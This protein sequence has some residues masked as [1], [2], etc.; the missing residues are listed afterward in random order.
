[1]I[2]G[3]GVDIVEVNRIKNIIEKWGNHFL[4]KVYSQ[5]EIF[6][7]ESKNSNRFQSYA[8]IFAAKEAFVKATGTGFRN[9]RWKEVKVVNDLLG[10]PYIYLS[11]QFKTRLKNMKIGSI[12]L[13]ISHTKSIAVA[14][15]VIEFDKNQG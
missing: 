10:K 1:M 2:N 11:R 4:N 13:S 3:C 8:G 7:C 12:H 14:Q 15:V 5:E 9:I 6:H